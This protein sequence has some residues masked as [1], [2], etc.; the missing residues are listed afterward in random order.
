MTIAHDAQGYHVY[1]EFSRKGIVVKRYATR[2]Y[3]RVESKKALL[4][5]SGDEIYFEI[6]GA[7]SVGIECG[8]SQYSFIRMARFMEV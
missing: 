2:E 1:N 5:R 4:L 8:G 6:Q 7:G 3:I